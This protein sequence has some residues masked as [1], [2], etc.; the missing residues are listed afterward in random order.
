MKISNHFKQSIKNPTKFSASEK[1]F[2]AATKTYTRLSCDPHVEKV[3]VLTKCLPDNI[4]HCIWVKMLQ[5]TFSSLC[6]LSLF[7][8]MLL[9][10]VTQSSLTKIKTTIKIIKTRI[11]TVAL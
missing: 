6:A 8:Y 7:L 11:S 5:N 9:K 4:T 10:S 1:K 2:P 3:Q